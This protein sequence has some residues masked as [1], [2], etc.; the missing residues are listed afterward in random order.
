MSSSSTYSVIEVMNGLLTVI[1][2]QAGCPE[3]GS[4]EGSRER[5]AGANHWERS[6]RDFPGKDLFIMDTSY[7]CFVLLHVVLYTVFV[8]LNRIYIMMCVACVT[9]VILDLSGLYRPS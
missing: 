5:T 6:E 4:G 8:F 1:R 9:F 2:R 3:D 7:C